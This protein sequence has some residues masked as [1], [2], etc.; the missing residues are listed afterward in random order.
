VQ[1]ILPNFFVCQGEFKYLFEGKSAIIR[2]LFR[3]YDVES[4]SI[5]ID[6]TD[7]STVTQN[8]LR[9]SVGVMPQDIVL[10]NKDTQVDH[11]SRRDGQKR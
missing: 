8:S 2:L 3:F 4:G 9:R 6:R 7:I 1:A 5:K 10:F 11:Y